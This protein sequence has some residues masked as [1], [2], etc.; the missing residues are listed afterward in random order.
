[1]KKK[2]SIRSI[3]VTTVTA[4]MTTLL[5]SSC[6]KDGDDTMVLPLNDGKVSRSVVAEEYQKNLRENGFTIHEGITPPNLE[7]VYIAAPLTL[8][9][10]SDGYTNNFFNLQMKFEHQFM[11]GMVN[12]SEQQR[13]TVEGVSTMSQVIG[14]DSCFTM[15]CVQYISEGTGINHLWSYKTATLISGI[16]TEQGIKD[17]QYAFV[18]LEKEAVSDYYYNQLAKLKTI[19]IWND[20]DNLASKIR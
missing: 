1:M 9:Y 11:R 17:F 10:A 13:D 8:Q 16:I 15:Y 3:A 18:M 4:L 14:H 7:G 12:Y 6:L 20:S 5:F 19:R 2:C